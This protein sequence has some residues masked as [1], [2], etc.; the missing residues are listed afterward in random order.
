MEVVWGTLSPHR[1]GIRL[2][3]VEERGLALDLLEFDTAAAFAPYEAL[4]LWLRVVED[5]RLESRQ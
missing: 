3:S 4:R 5:G 1:P 2:I